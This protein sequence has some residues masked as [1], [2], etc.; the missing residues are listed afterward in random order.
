MSA[1]FDYQPELKQLRQRFS[2]EAFHPAEP[3]SLEQLDQMGIPS[4]IK[5]FY[6]AAEP[7]EI[8]E[9]EGVFLLPVWKI[10][11]AM[12]YTAPGIAARKYGSVVIATTVSGDAYGLATDEADRSGEMPVYLINHER[13]TET[14]SRQLMA[15]NRHHIT[16]SFRDFLKR[17]IDGTLP[18]DYHQARSVP[19]PH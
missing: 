14:A 18:Y 1:A 4:H 2:P 8:L 16:R 17:F 7:R 6:A 11:D 5:A 19:P 13:V 12:T 10:V 3:A 9:S 15:Q